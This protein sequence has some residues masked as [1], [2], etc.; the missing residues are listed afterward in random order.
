LTGLEALVDDY[1]AHCRAKGLS[2]KTI[3]DNYGYALKGLFLPLAILRCRA[4]GWSCLAFP[5][6]W[7]SPA[8][9]KANPA[10]APKEE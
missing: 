7:E 10:G 1:L 3:R 9:L 5:G 4:A 6:A 2:P 8:G